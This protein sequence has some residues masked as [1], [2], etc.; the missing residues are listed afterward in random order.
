MSYYVEFKTK[1]G[2]YRRKRTK[3]RACYA[4][5]D[6]QE[7]QKDEGVYDPEFLANVYREVT[8]QSSLEALNRGLKD[9]KIMLDLLDDNDRLKWE[10]QKGSKKG[11][12]VLEAPL[13]RK[14]ITDT[15][16]RHDLLQ[17][18]RTVPA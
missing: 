14:S 7:I 17:H 13:R 12:S 3:Q 16:K 10:E 1:D 18:R 6:E 4:V 5:L 15:L 2:S 9:Q 11:S 8:G